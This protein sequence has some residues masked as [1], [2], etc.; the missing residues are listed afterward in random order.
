MIIERRSVGVAILLAFL[1]CGIYTLYWDYKMWDSLYK[2]NKMQSRAG[3]DLVLALVTCG[4][5]YIYMHYKAGKLESSAHHLHGLTPTDDSILYIILTIFGLG[6]VSM[7]IL[8][9]NI[10]KNLVDVVNDDHIRSVAGGAGHDQQ[11]GQF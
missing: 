4:I 11:R 6:L 10:N 3:T 2:A 5:Y 9:S 1:T 7:A 8:Q